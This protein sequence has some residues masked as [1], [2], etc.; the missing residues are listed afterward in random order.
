VPHFK[1][2]RND[3][4]PRLPK[5]FQ[6]NYY[7][8]R[9]VVLRATCRRPGCAR[10]YAGPLV[11]SRPGTGLVC[12]QLRIL[13]GNASLR[14]ARFGGHARRGNASS[15]IGQLAYHAASAGGSTAV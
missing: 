11:A 3:A 13:P 4:K 10:P 12:R 15:G 8:L 6:Q 1:T 5:A 9:K 2:M 14:C 7:L